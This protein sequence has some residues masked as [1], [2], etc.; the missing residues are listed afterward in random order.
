MPVGNVEKDPG[1]A[2]DVGQELP[3]ELATGMPRPLTYYVELLNKNGR[4]AGMSN[5][6]VVAAGEAPAAVLGL[7]A[8][9]QKIGVVLHWNAAIEGPEAT[10]VRLQRKLLTPVAE[11]AAKTAQNPIAPAS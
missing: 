2:V 9:I 3:E 8:Q 7:D 10:A 11:P 4:S 1:A 6:A 5:P